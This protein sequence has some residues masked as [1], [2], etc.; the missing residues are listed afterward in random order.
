MRKL[1]VALVFGFVAMGAVPA[2]ATTIPISIHVDFSNADGDGPS[3]STLDTT[4][5]LPGGIT[6][7]TLNITQYSPDD[8]SV[9]FLNGTNVSDSGIFGPGLGSFYFL[10]DASDLQVYTFS[11]GSNDTSFDPITDPFV[12]GLNTLHFIINNT[13][14]GIIGGPVD[15]GPS[16]LDFEATVTFDTTATPLPAAF[17]LFA[18]GLG[19]LGWAARRRKQKQLAA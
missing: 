6:N 13:N 17:P 1:A 14:T 9:L 18:T 2:G 16:N 8:R 4:F 7:T 5:T 10:P 12:T 15:F 3:Y 19:V 11:H